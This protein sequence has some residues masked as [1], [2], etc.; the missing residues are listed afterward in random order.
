MH[1]AIKG[2]VINFILLATF[3]EVNLDKNPCIVPLYRHIL[4]LESIDKHIS[5]LDF[6]TISS[7]GLIIDLKNST[8]LFSASRIKSCPTCHGPL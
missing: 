3:K 8:K 5:I 7:E 6:Y 4:A 1:L 2:I